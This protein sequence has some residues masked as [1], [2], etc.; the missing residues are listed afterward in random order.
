MGSDDG[1]AG[2]SCVVAVLGDDP[3]PLNPDRSTGT[4]SRCPLLVREHHPQ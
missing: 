1:G 4:L 2:K 3:H